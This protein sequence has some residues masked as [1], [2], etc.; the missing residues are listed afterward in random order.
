MEFHVGNLPVRSMFGRALVHSE[1]GL[2][3]DGKCAEVSAADLVLDLA[4]LFDVVAD[5]AHDEEAVVVHRGLPNAAIAIGV[6]GKH[7]T[8]LNTTVRQLHVAVGGVGHEAAERLLE[9]ANGDSIS[10]L[11]DHVDAG[12]SSNHESAVGS[13]RLQNEVR[14]GCG[15]CGCGHY[16]PNIVLCYIK[17]LE[18]DLRRFRSQ[19][20]PLLWLPASFCWD[21]EGLRRAHQF[22][23]HPRPPHPRR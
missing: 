16:P 12:V 19:F 4:G 6:G 5:P 13:V 22:P 8:D 11:V 7:L 15:P 18:P 20:Q 17:G 10:L 3:S 2:P 9:G 14:S 1:Q 23:H 21:N